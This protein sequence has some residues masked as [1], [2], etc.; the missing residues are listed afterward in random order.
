MM[1][2]DANEVASITLLK[3]G[4]STAIYGSRGA[5]GVVVITTKEPEMGKLALTY[6]GSVNIEVPDLTEY[7]LLSAK[8][9]LKLE[10]LSGYYESYS[11]S[12]DYYIH[13]GRC[14]KGSEHLL[15]IKTIKNGRGAPP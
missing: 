8:D 14:G 5:N 6:N 2:L 7:R 3:D 12:R 9:K 4:T 10:Q 13:L 1:D 11:P 15:A